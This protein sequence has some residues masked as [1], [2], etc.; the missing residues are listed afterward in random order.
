MKLIN[1][2]KK[3]FD[4]ACFNLA[5]DIISHNS[6]P[7]IIISIAKGGSYVGSNIYKYL[8][9]INSNIK[10]C[11][12]TI[13]R[14]CTVF[15]KNIGI[16]KI[17][18][19]IPNTLLN[20]IRQINIYVHEFIYEHFNPNIKRKGNVDIPNE[21]IEYINQKDPI[22]ILIVDDAVDSGTTLEIVT[23]YIKDLNYSY[24]NQVIFYAVLTTTYKHPKIIP[25]FTLYNRTI[26]R[27]PWA[28][29]S[30]KFK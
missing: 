16:K 2:L 29:D 10:Y 12:V 23:N 25:N 4:E 11:E 6:I 7:D 19:F 30:F 21:I 5:S 27:F 20:W 15:M 8:K 18:K 22:K 24:S 13:Q 17:F 28:F 9:I 3:D 1:C 26:L 14:P